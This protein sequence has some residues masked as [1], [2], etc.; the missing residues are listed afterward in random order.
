MGKYF[1]E[2]R[3]PSALISRDRWVC[4][5]LQPRNDKF[6]KAHK[7]SHGLCDVHLRFLRVVEILKS[8]KELGS[9]GGDGIGF[10]LNG[11][12]IVG[13]DLDVTASPGIA[14]TL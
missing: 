1:F 13:I 7:P 12:G 4:W 6:T 8:A 5:R 2:S 11:D 10:V 14:K 3:I 9:F